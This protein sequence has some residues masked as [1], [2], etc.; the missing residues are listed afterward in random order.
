MQIVKC[1][2]SGFTRFIRRKLAEK[3]LVFKDVN[4]VCVLG[5]D[6]AL[7]QTSYNSNE[8]AFSLLTQVIGRAGRWQKDA[9]AVVQTYDSTNPVIS[10][11]QKADYESFYNG[12]IAFRQM[13]IYPPFCTMCQVAFTNEKEISA[14][15]D[16]AKFLAIIRAQSHKLQGTP[17]VVLGPAPFSVSMVSGIHRY[18]L[19]L[20][21]KNTKSFRDFLRLCIDEYLRDTDNKSGIYVNMNPV[22]E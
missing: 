17:L 3:G 6:G 7:N 11:A 8:N 1:A 15:K 5:I 13:N 20:K 10:L 21:C 18:R 2:K 16:A 9:L 12:E 22:Q 14:A 19:T 4:M